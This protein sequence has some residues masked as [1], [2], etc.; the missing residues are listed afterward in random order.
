M[1][2]QE[3]AFQHVKVHVVENAKECVPAP[4]RDLVHQVVRVVVAV[5]VKDH[6][7]EPQKDPDGNKISYY[8]YESISPESIKPLLE[9]IKNTKHEKKLN[10]YI[11]SKGGM[12]PVAIGVYNFIKSIENLKITTYN[13]GHCD[14]AAILLFMLG[15]KR[16][17]LQNSSFYFHSLQIKLKEKQTINSLKSELLNLTNDTKNF[18]NILSENSKISKKQWKIWM[19]DNGTL[20]RAKKAINVGLVNE[21]ITNS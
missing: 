11:N 9:F 8:L 16:Y 19:S 7:V 4:A 17:A 3:L 21:I 10:I 15:E 13:M 18:I 20:L 5:L 12:V 1:D 6:V 14:S 2:V